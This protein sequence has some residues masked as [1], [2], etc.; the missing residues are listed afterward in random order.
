[1]LLLVHQLLEAGGI[2]GED[3][4]LAGT[5]MGDQRLQIAIEVLVRRALEG[6]QRQTTCCSRA[7][8]RWK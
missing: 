7:S 3:G 4:I 6:G 8:S 1:V 2:L 5:V